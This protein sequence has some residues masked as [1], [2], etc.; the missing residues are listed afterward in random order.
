V[1]RRRREKKTVP[2]PAPTMAELTAEAVG[3]VFVA[4]EV[5]LAQL[6]QN[7]RAGPYG[8]LLCGWC[9][10][11]EGPQCKRE[12]TPCSFYG[13]EC[14][15]RAERSHDVTQPIAALLVTETPSTDEHIRHALTRIVTEPLIA[16]ED[17]IPTPVTPDDLERAFGPG[18][19]WGPSIL[20]NPELRRAVR[21]LA[22]AEK[23]ASIFLG[24]TPA[25]DPR[26]GSG[27]RDAI[28]QDPTLAGLL[29]GL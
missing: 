4:S 18:G 12:H 19:T 16:L 8:A 26:D 1:T 11:R 21:D 29:E 9:Q 15:C 24:D 7:L 17:T 20:E 23:A 28:S 2:A 27:V 10:R 13:C 3:R 22:V 25:E 14:F 6:T 5:P